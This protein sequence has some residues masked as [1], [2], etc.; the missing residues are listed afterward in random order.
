M[1]LSIMITDEA[2]GAEM[3]L[4]GR[5]VEISLLTL[6]INLARWVQSCPVLYV[7]KQIQQ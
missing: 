6:A 1:P 5:F 2:L 7:L 4:A 3:C